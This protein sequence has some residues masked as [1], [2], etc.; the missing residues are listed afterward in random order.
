MSTKKKFNIIDIII[1]AVI[2][3]VIAGVCTMLFGKTDTS[4]PNAPKYSKTV[5]IEGLQK[6]QTF[7]NLVKEGDKIFD[8]VSKKEL[9]VLKSKEI[10]D[11][12]VQ[13]TASEE[14]K[15]KKVPVPDK[16]DIY[17]TIEV[18]NPEITANIGTNISIHS[19]MYVLSGHIVDIID[20]AEVSK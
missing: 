11:D 16:Y 5:V 14:G 18:T 13:T 4:A 1:V 20:D 15:I 10:K 9:G 7:C 17:L 2:I 12:T 6:S 19:K 8:T 3:A